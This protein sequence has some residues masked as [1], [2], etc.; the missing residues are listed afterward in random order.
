MSIYE[1][2]ETNPGEEVKSSIRKPR[3]MDNRG[4]EVKS[5]KAQEMFDS[6]T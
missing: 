1:T 2:E 4:E 5:S 6:R 3:A